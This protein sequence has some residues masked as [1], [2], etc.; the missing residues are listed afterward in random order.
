MNYKRYDFNQKECIA[1]M[2]FGRLISVKEKLPELGETVICYFAGDEDAEDCQEA[3][4]M[5]LKRNDND[6]RD[7]FPWYGLRIDLQERV[8]H[9]KRLYQKVLE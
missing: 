6:N 8:T 5:I 9:W 4:I 3:D 2:P 7:I 1:F